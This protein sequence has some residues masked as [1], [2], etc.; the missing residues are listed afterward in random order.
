MACVFLLGWGMPA[1]SQLIPFPPK[2]PQLPTAPPPVQP[3]ALE[4]P[5][6]RPPGTMEQAITGPKI[7]VKEVRLVGNT[8]FTSQ[9]LSEITAPYTNRELT[10]EDLEGLRLALT[11]H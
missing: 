9:Q 2:P 10:A 7:L 5:S 11:H 3:P 1:H 6:P 4:V 8:A